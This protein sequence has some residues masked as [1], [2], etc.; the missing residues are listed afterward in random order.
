MVA[1]VVSVLGLAG[2]ADAQADGVRDL[3][4]VTDSVGLAILPGYADTAGTIDDDLPGEWQLTLD[5]LVN[6]RTSAG[7][8]ILRGL[9]GQLDD[10][11]VIG[12]G[13]NDG[14][15]Q[16]DLDAVMAELAGSEVVVW[17]TLREAGTYAALYRQA[18]DR[19]RAATIIYPNLVLADWN[20]ASIGRSDLTAR[21]GLHLTSLG[22]RAMADLLADTIGAGLAAGATPPQPARPCPT[23]APMAAGAGSRFVPIDP[24]R[25]LDTRTGPQ[26]TGALR[27]GDT[28]DVQV[29]G[30]AGIPDGAGGAV[31]LNVTSTEATAPSYVTL[32]PTGQPRP[33]ASALNPLPG[34]DRANLTVGQIGAGGRVSLYNNAGTGHLVAD[35]V[36]WFPDDVAFRPVGPT[37]VLDTRDG[38]GVQGGRPFL[39]GPGST[40]ALDVAG[41]AGVPDTGVAAVVLNVTSTAASAPSFVTVWA[42]EDGA[43]P[44]TS[45]LNTEPGHDTSN[46]AVV[47]VGASGQL[48]LYNNAGTGHL[49]ADVVGYL[50]AGPAYTPVTPSRVL[51]TRTGNGAPVGAIGPAGRIDVQ[52]AGRGDVPASANAVV[53][54]LTSTAASAPSYVTVWPAG[55][56]QPQASSLNVAPGLDVANLVVAEVGTGGQVSLYSNAGTGHLVADVVGYLA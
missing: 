30:C 22:A 34:R 36:G 9:A 32:W 27:S 48:L 40:I 53:L 51:D 2:P 25:V 39:L 3:V 29:A 55:Q 5:G 6:R 16:T 49:V 20:A 31:V 13:Y 54:N 12:L 21:D 1:L 50:P 24:A 52:I 17:L 15:P 10:V 56:P 44:P 38:I 19:L 46:L 33:T 14:L 7:P 37:R 28:I 4:I 11:V 26:Y 35:V 41:R 42:P 23:D 8:G 47:R 18:N 43:R 45:T